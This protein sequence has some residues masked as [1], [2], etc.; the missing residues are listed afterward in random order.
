MGLEFIKLNPHAEEE[1]LGLSA[2]QAAGGICIVEVISF[3]TESITLEKIQTEPPT[4][5]FWRRFGQELAQFHST[6]VNW[7]GFTIDNHIGLTAQPNPKIACSE[8][9]WEEYFVEH[10]L[11]QMLCHPR[12]SSH[13]QL[14]ALF[15]KAEPTI[16]RIL[17]RVTE[18]PCLVHGDLWSGNFLCAEGQT[19]VLI[20]PAPYWGHR[21]V[22]IAMSELFGGF[23][24]LFYQ[25]YD[26]Q[27]KL[28]PGYEQR[29]DIYNLYHVLNHWILFGGGYANQAL[30]LLERTINL[31]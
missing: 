24:P 5:K 15:G 25:S 28:K 2:L 1:A 8:I 12:L 19:P 9:S 26:E 29:R 16:L 7:Y 18:K 10:R 23:D 31:K 14:Q 27:L 6:P 30:S 20:D 3:D 17:E 21:E 13:G 11:K 22:D 4:A